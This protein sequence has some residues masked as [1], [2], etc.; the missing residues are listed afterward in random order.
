MIDEYLDRLDRCLRGPARL[1]ADLLT[2]ARHGLQDAAA[3]YRD[4]GLAAAEAERRAVTEFGSVPELAG[5]Y[6]AEVA[7]L[8]IR[9]F[10]L[11]IVGVWL[12]LATTGDLMWRGAPWTGARPSAGY[13]LLAASVSWVWLAVGLTAAAGYLYLTWTA[14]RGRTAGFRLHRALGRGLTG[15]LGLGVL[16]GIALSVWSLLRWEEARSW[17]PLLLGV[18]GMLLAQ[19]WLG[20]NA[21][22]CVL[23]TARSTG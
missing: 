22:T 11:R 20:W 4:V 23:V 12:V 10:A 7:A 19:A 6:Q 21:R 13:R 14:R 2:E 18:T 9:R 16:L 15:S 5:A 1:K 17:P 8:A 3:G